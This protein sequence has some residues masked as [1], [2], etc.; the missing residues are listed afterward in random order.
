MHSEELYRKVDVVGV[1]IK[2]EKS[3]DINRAT[4]S[5]VAERKDSGIPLRTRL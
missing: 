2:T 1:P 5:E 3:E 4:S